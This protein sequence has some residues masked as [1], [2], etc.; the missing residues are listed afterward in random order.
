VSIPYTILGGYLGA[1]KTTLLNRLLADN[2]GLRL[3]LLIND[4]GAIN[5][6]AQ[7]IASRTDDQINLTNGCI[8]CGLSAGFDEAIDQLLARQPPPDRIIVE[9]SGVADVV[10]LA[11]YGHHPGLRLD[12]VIV[13]ADAETVRSKARDKYVATT[14]T[15]QLEGADLIILNKTDLIDRTQRSDLLDWLGTLAPET[16]VIPTSYCQVSKDLLLG[17][18]HR[19]R[20]PTRHPGHETYATWYFE[21]KSPLAAE[22][23]DG[24]VTALPPS[25]LRAKGFFNLT[26]GKRLLYQRVGRRD[27]L[28]S[29]ETTGP[30]ELVMIGLAAELPSDTLDQLAG[31]LIGTV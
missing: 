15:R 28:E 4:F 11:Q 21:T 25:V 24:F 31:R 29:S 27:T 10:S 16:P 26:S 19:P 17:F 9:A 2:D 18:D 3:A 12:G 5:I 20:E 8:C 14:V 13:V 22:S 6:D 23:V 1:G 7:L 30:T